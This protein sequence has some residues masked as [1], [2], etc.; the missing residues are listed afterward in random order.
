MR[1]WARSA[2]LIGA[3]LAVGCA[4]TPKYA[5]EDCPLYSDLGPLVANPAGALERRL[6]VEASFRV[7]PP[8]EGLAEIQRKR[9]ELKHQLLALL[10]SKTAADLNHPQRVEILQQEIRAVVNQ[11]VLKRGRVVDVY[12]TGFELQ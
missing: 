1:G 12:I 10:S 5:R 11:K 4:S 7:C 2:A 3:L 9:I 8:G 6:R